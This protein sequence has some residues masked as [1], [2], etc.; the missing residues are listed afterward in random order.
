[1]KF[2][3]LFLF[4]IICYCLI[5]CSRQHALQTSNK[6]KH[7]SYSDDQ[8]QSDYEALVRGTSL[9]VKSDIPKQ[10]SIAE[11]P[12]CVG[13][14]SE[15]TQ[16]YED[17]N[18]LKTIL[19]FEKGQQ[20]VYYN[21]TNNIIRVGFGS[22]N[23]YVSRYAIA[24]EQPYTPAEYKTINWHAEYGTYNYIPNQNL[25]TNYSK[26]TKSDYSHSYSKFNAPVSSSEKTVHVKGYLKKNGTYVQPYN[27][28]PPRKH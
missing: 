16:L 5:G 8:R 6:S 26:T 14:A 21:T 3:F 1:M 15:N 27:R 9:E 4:A 23:G 11:Y 18:M 7:L 19:V 10:Y 13:T 12:Y 22:K 25:N 17:S 20:F 24:Y 2:K 28:R